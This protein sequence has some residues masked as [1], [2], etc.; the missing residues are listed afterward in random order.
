MCTDVTQCPTCKHPK[1]KISQ[2]IEVAHTF[3]LD[4]KYTKVMGATYLQTT[5]KPTPLVMGCYGIGITRLIAA[6]IECLSNENEIRWPFVLA[7]FNVC[8]IPPKDGSKEQDAVRQYTD[9]I[10]NQLNEITALNDQVIIDDRSNLTI[11]KR[12]MEAKRFVYYEDY[13]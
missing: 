8:I 13:L 9:Q 3:L 5:G 1:L 12:L 7:P 4:D 10:Y 2:G 6:S 11:G